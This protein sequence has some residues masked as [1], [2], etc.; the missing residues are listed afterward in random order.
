MFDIE[1]VKISNCPS[2][3]VPS[4]ARIFVGF[5]PA[6]PDGECTVKGFVD[7]KTGEFHIQEIEYHK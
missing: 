6:S 7:R 1:H 4:D 3:V 2:N 5:D